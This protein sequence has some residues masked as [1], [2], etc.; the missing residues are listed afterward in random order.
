VCE[1]LQLSFRYLED[2]A[3]AEVTVSNH[4]LDICACIDSRVNLEVACR[5]LID[6]ILLE[7]LRDAPEEMCLFP[8]H[9][10][11]AKVPSTSGNVVLHGE[12]DYL[13]SKIALGR[14]EGSASDRTRYIKSQLH[15]GDAAPAIPFCIVVEAKRGEDFMK[16]KG[17]LIAE[18]V[19]AR[20]KSESAGINGIL[21][22]GNSW[23]FYRLE[24]T[25]LEMSPI[26][27][28]GQDLK[29]IVGI[30]TNLFKGGTLTQLCAQEE[31]DFSNCLF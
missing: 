10:L 25:T 28:R 7:G 27:E 16:G 1:E 18:M 17:Q 4:L 29:K 5:M 14:F 6:V 20:S 31:Q 11:E 3:Y 26:L 2:E 13:L 24:N 23:Q 8:E 30:L 9:S 12:P 22:S 15:Y 21:T 19:A